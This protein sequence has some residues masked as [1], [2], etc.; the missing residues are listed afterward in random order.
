[1]QES[2]RTL[3]AHRLHI[4]PNQGC[5]CAWFAQPA[6]LKIAHTFRGVAHS[7]Q[8]RL[9]LVPQVT[10]SGLPVDRILLCS[11]Q[12]LFE[13]TVFHI[14]HKTV[15]GLAFQLGKFFF[16]AAMLTTRNISGSCALVVDIKG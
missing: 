10:V 16:G 13:L 15:G 14:H 2:G 1:L 6:F 5:F 4:C 11:G 8:I 3:S 12:L 7:I 9:N